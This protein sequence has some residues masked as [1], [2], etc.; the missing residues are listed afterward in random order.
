MWQPTMGSKAEIYISSGPRATLGNV[1]VTF[2]FLFAAQGDTKWSRSAFLKYQNR[3][4]EDMAC[5]RR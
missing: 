1:W 4:D 2:S 5:Q 3:L